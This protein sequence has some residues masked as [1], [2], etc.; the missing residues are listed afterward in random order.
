[1]QQKFI[2]PDGSYGELITGATTLLFAQTQL[3]ASNLTSGFDPSSLLKKPPA[4]EIAFLTHD[5]E[6][7][8]A[9]AL[10][11]GTVA[12]APAV[13]KP[14]GQTVA[15]VRDPNGFLIDICTPMA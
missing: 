14:H 11:A 13:Y 6:A 15:Y 1:M 3:A 7:A 9:R 8:Y 2:T 4:M 5:V 10:L 12:E